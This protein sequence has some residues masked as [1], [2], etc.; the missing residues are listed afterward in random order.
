MR[1]RRGGIGCGGRPM[2]R[3]P[4][5]N[6]AVRT[7]AAARSCDRQPG[8]FE[9]PAEAFR[10]VALCGLINLIAAMPCLMLMHKVF[11]HDP[12]HPGRNVWLTSS[13]TKTTQRAATAMT[14]TFSATMGGALTRA[15]ATCSTK[16]PGA[17]C[18][19]GL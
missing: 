4:R 14:P 10:I 7:V 16:Q 19:T 1:A 17:T 15:A 12:M 8:L 6:R 13:A 18:P 11:A 9:S 2:S 5:R 3:D